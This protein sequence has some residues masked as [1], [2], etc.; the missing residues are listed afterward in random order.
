MS[1]T[2]AEKAAI[3]TKALEDKDSLENLVARTT[4][5]ALTI[6]LTEDWTGNTELGYLTGRD[7]LNWLDEC[8]KVFE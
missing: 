2:D 8:R 7:V 4:I 3:L 1:A 5:E 6:R